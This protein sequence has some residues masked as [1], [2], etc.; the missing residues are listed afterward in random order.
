VLVLVADAHRD[1]HRHDAAVEAGPVRVDELFVAGDM[2]D[3][4]VAWP[5]PDPL[6]VEQ[7][8]E[9]AALEV[10]QPERPL[11]AFAFEVNDRAVAAGAVV[12]HRGERRVLDHRCSILM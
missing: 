3:K 9:R 5:G 10:R 12:E 8:A 7:D 4:V 2:Q 6:Q 11:R 1:R